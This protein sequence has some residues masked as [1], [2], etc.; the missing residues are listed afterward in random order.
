[1][2][3][4]SGIEEGEMDGGGRPDTDELHKGER[5]RIVEIVAEEIR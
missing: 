4:E 1:M 2:L 3:R 5:R